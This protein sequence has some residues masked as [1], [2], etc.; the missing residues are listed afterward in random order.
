MLNNVKGKGVEVDPD[1]KTLL[2]NSNLEKKNGKETEIGKRQQCALGE[3]K[4]P[5]TGG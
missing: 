4:N 5:C 1:I 3:K 2:L